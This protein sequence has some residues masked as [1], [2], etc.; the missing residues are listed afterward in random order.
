MDRLLVRILSFSAAVLFALL[1][2]RLIAQ[3]PRYSLAVVFVVLAFALPAW[4]SRRRM[5]RVLL[6]GDV[7][8]VLGT[9]EGSLRRITYPETMAPLMTATAYAA[10]GFIDEARNALTRAAK[11]PAWSRSAT[12][13]GSGAAR[14]RSDLLC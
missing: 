1:S 10:Y 14:D 12:R 3:D 11:G 9:W 8:R 2:A 7:E 4:L 13:A 6:S 5:R